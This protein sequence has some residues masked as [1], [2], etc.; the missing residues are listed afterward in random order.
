MHGKLDKL[1]K[2]LN[3][4]LMATVA[5]CRCQG[6]RPGTVEEVAELRG[7]RLGGSGTVRQSSGGVQ[8]AW[9]GAERCDKDGLARVVRVAL[10]SGAEEE[11]NS[12][13][14]LAAAQGTKREK[15]K[16]GMKKGARWI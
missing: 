12:G 11:A 15:K 3:L 1:K 4:K 10:T 9:R 13:K 7:W 8:A 14:A 2:N 6:R 5:G 16:M